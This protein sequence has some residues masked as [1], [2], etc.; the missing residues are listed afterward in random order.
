VRQ[1]CVSERLRQI[2][3]HKDGLEMKDLRTICNITGA[4]NAYRAIEEDKSA[5]NL[6]E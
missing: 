3:V 1:T 2:V 5:T 6:C 4:G